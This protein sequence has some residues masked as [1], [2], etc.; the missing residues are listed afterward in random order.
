V[1]WF[2]TQRNNCSLPHRKQTSLFN[3]LQP[4]T[5]GANAPIIT[6]PGTYVRVHCPAAQT[7]TAIDS[8]IE[9]QLL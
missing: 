5:Y 4:G 9:V 1:L 3:F 2:C 7:L 6:I 8:L